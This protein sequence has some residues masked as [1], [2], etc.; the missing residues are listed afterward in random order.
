M[1]AVPSTGVFSKKAKG[2]GTD[3]TRDSAGNTCQVDALFYWLVWIPT[4]RQGS[5][6]WTTFITREPEGTVN[7]E[8][9]TDD[10]VDARLRTSEWNHTLR[11][12]QDVSGT[13]DIA[14]MASGMLK[15]MWDS[16]YTSGYS[17]REDIGLDQKL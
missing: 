15:D 12:S 13:V 16:T 5:L 3:F 14:R 17:A 2:V 1:F 8:Y 6:G 4:R 10:E 9:L 7:C 11:T